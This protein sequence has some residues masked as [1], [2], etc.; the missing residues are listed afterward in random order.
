MK[1]LRL[2]L[3]L[4]VLSTLA[5]LPG[6][7]AFPAWLPIVTDILAVVTQAQNT[8]QQIE[9]AA[10]PFVKL[11][12][13]DK[14]IAVSKAEA[15]I[16]QAL[17]TLGALSHAAKDL[18]QQDVDKAFAEFADAYRQLLGLLQDAGIM[19]HAP[20]GDAHA[21]AFKA[22]PGAPPIV[23]EDPIAARPHPVQ[24]RW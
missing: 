11:L 4:A 15:R 21:H 16:S 7:A 13:E 14:Q 1:R 10:A 23:V 6:C 9:A 22:E 17:A 20:G 5:A 19:V 24:V 2:F 3:A 18:Q 8:T 12:P